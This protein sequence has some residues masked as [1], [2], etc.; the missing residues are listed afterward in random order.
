MASKT[1]KL[2]IVRKRK[3]KSNKTNQKVRQRII[4]RNND[5]ANKD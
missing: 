3:Q 1:V 2:K 4:D 5:I